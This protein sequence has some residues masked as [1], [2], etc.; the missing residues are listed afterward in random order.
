MSS[1]NAG[2]PKIAARGFANERAT[3]QK[4]DDGSHESQDA[5]HLSHV[6]S[7]SQDK[8]RFLNPNGQELCPINL[9]MKCICLAINGSYLLCPSR[10]AAGQVDDCRAVDPTDHQ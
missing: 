3:Q 5:E 9:H 7:S 1:I 8:L 10:W 4:T 6:E 2:A